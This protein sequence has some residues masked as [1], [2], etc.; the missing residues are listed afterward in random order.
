MVGKFWE[1]RGGLKLIDEIN[2]LC[3]REGWQANGQAVHKWDQNELYTAQEIDEGHTTAIVNRC[4]YED[5][6]AVDE[7]AYKWN[8][9]DGMNTHGK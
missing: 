9:E 8:T 2:A 5:S 6:V 3:F 4:T 7:V 1:G